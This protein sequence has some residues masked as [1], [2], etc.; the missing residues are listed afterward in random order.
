[1]KLFL[2]IIIISL[3]VIITTKNTIIGVVSLIFIF[4][5]SVFILF[6]FN[7]M[8]NFIAFTYLI[9]YVGAISVL[10]IFVVMMIEP[11]MSVNKENINLIFFILI[12]Y[13]LT[14][15][16]FNDTIIIQ[17]STWNIFKWNNF[18]LSLISEYLYSVNPLVL[19]LASKLLLLAIIAPIYLLV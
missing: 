6:F 5:N 11:S 17:D 12:I 7:P 15:V 4:I 10:L 18:N 9:V 14:S 3:L 16:E 19:L 2:I 8:D 1:M 13:Y